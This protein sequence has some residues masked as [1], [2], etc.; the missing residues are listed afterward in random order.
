MA[1]QA[2]LVGLPNVGKST[3]FNAL[4]KSGVP[5]QNY[6]F[7][8]IDPHVAITHVP[9]ERLDKLAQI[10]KSQKIV[11]ATVQFSDIA[12]LVKGASKGEGLGNQFLANIMNVDLILH[13]V[14]CFEDEN[15][16]HVHNAINPVD[17]LEVIF[18]ELMLKDLES[19][20]KRETK[21]AELLRTAKNR[22]LSTQQIKDL[23]NE[24]NLIDEV[25]TAL[26]TGDLK[27]IQNI[28][29]K[30]KEDEIETIP[31][32]SSKNYLIIANMSE[33][34]M[35]G[36][37]YKTNQNYQML[38]EKFGQ[39][40]IIPVCAKIEEELAQLPDTEKTEMLESLEIEGSGLNDIIKKTYSNLGLITF[41][42]SGPK[43]AH[44]WTVKK[45]TKIPQAAGEIHSD[46]Q[47]GFICTEVYSCYD[48]FELKSETALKNV[49]KIRTEG[50]NYIVQDGD[51]VLIRFNV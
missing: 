51:V 10:F 25:K 27:K 45:D 8:T 46:M 6:P 32:L 22:N 26:Q 24:K 37:N 44:S 49:G 15:I 19:I 16:T 33:D 13:I 43:E 31:L 36:Q 17:D 23:E 35:Q 48:L 47:R 21:L 50:K 34:D 42:T 11:P 1:I 12:G 3:L 29:K 4:T 7:C 20:E 5:A 41:F 18:A 39:D 40:C 28:A 38:V 2:G 14:R 30:Y 9:D